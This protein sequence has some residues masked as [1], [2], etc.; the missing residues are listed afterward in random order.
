MEGEREGRASEGNQSQARSKM[1]PTNQTRDDVRRRLEGGQSQPRREVERRCEQGKGR[2]KEGSEG[3]LD[4][5]WELIDDL[6]SDQTEMSSD[7]RVHK[8]RLPKA[9]SDQQLAFL[10][11]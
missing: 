3:M 2:E 8:P 9:Y 11:R 1:A 10:K 4:A 5:S 7:P 6:L